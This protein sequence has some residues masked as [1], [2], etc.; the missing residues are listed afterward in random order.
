MRWEA[1]VADSGSYISTR[2]VWLRGKKVLLD[3]DLASLYG[4]TTA[5]LNEQVKRNTD[6]FPSDFAFRLTNH[7]FMALMSQIATSNTTR[8][9]TRAIQMSV[10]RGTRVCPP[11]RHTDRA[12]G[13]GKKARRAGAK[14]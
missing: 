5:R 13:F 14:G 4:V 1:A 3:A 9:G 8:G 10:L 2:I 7:E 6:R 12:Q 11:A